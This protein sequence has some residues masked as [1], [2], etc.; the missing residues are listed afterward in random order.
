[1]KQSS[2]KTAAIY[3]RLSREDSLDGESNSIS[4]QKKLLTKAA[5]E[6][7]YTKLLHYTDDGIT[8]TTMNR[9]GFSSM[10]ADIKSGIIGAVFVKDMSRLGRNYLQVG[11][12]TEDF[13][14]EHNIRLVAVSDGVDSAE[15]E[16][17]FTPFRNIMNE[18]YA[19][20]I[21]RKVRTAQKI[22]GESGIPL[23]NVPYGYK[24]N[25]D[26]PKFWLVDEE[27]AAIVRRIFDLS[28]GG[29]GV[30]QIA[31]TLESENIPTP[32]NYWKSKGIKRGGKPYSQ[33]STRWNG[34][35][36]SNILALQEY[37]GDVVN[38]KT[39]KPSYKSKKQYVN[40][41]ED[42]AI[43]KDVHQP[44][45]DRA[46][47]EK[48][49]S[50]RGK[51]RKRKLKSGERNMFCG[52]VVCADCGT[53]LA[54]HKNSVSEI[55]Y[56]NCQEFNRKNRT[57][58]TSHY[59]RVDFL[60][61]VVLSEVRRLT[62]FAGKHQ[63][64]FANAMLGFTQDAEQLERKRKQK[65]LQK[66]QARDREI[67]GI[68]QKMY[69]DTVSGKLTDER[70]TKL[71]HSY[72]NEQKELAISISKLEAELQQQNKQ[73]DTIDSFIKSVRKYT[74]AK[75]LTPHLLNE[76]IQRIEV[77]QSEKINGVHV[78]NIKIYYHCIGAIDM[79]E[80]IPDATI[81]MNTR[82]GVN[83]AYSTSKRAI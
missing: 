75:K 22:K 61:Q 36:I 65:E 17:E 45:I 74:R 42:R 60:E 44:I 43:F 11:Y 67:D 69:E 55:E 68:I 4:N 37:C 14:P 31:A 8:G 57:C 6:K 16:N 25:P 39:H 30:E 28:I 29:M 58:P 78:Q 32:T 35:T 64:V 12:Y 82:Q 18:W 7:G 50:K 21:S 59:I 66:L 27:A 34:S 77:S 24:R 52:L 54:Y 10:I 76:L 56:F 53:N 3:L 62:K 38:F 48:V 81:Q 1:M 79:P 26:N 2:S 20:D 33:S 47:F 15:G 9:P 49:Q 13:F 63:D 23:G 19:R 5:K 72:E 71:S 83:I 70:F 73:A 80:I 46:T 51:M 40:E 41:V